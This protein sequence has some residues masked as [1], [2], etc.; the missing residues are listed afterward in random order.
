MAQIPL[1][2]HENPSEERQVISVS[3]LNSQIKNLL[4]G[5]I[6]QIW[7]KGEISNFKAHSSGHLYFSLKDQNSQ[8]RAVMFRTQ[9]MRLKFRAQDGQEVLCRGSI[10]VYVPRGD[11]QIYVEHM[12]PLG[13][14]A[15]QRAFEELK[16]KLAAEGLF[17][18]T[19]KRPL[20]KRPR[21][22][23]VVTS[24]TGAAI[25][26]ILSIL[27][28]RA[29]S[30][31][32]IVVP[33][34][35]QG[36]AAGPDLIRAFHQAQKIP[37]V[38]TIIIG[39]GGGSI[40][41][42]WC[43]N[44]ESLARAIAAS[45]IPVISA[46][47]H[48][49]DFTIA[50]FVADV[51]APTPSAAAELVATPDREYLEKFILSEERLVYLIGQLV[52]RLSDKWSHLKARLVDPSRRLRELYERAVELRSRLVQA[53]TRWQVAHT[54]KIQFLHHRLLTHPPQVQ[55]RLE[56]VNHLRTL[57]QQSMLTV[58]DKKNWSF[59][60]LATLLDSLSP[61]AVLARGYSYQTN[62][63]AQVLSS[64]YQVRLGDQVVTHVKDGQWISQILEIYPSQEKPEALSG[65]DPMREK[66]VAT[67]KRPSKHSGK[68]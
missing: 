24:P 2:L 48:E 56:Q 64:V 53:Q 5:Q 47:G 59:L 30:I 62:E 31:P 6:G 42:M 15:L 27:S 44:D 21:K 57:L 20:P 1:L 29:P 60:R 34:L 19:K 55:E 35:V 54:Q 67:D 23:A 32:V 58:W 37:A 65:G 7:L 50:D 3:E 49:I 10:S 36:A 38:D 63:K 4:E 11:Y 9:A 66:K 39:R 43:F 40:E 68:T 14:G 18:P 28:R 16:R 26:D 22:I 61:L 46:V 51:R 12:E 33:A 25:R 13:A 17:D 45:P 52:S 8:I 41:D